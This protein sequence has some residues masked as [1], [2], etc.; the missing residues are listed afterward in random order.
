M[1]SSN[2]MFFCLDTCY[3]LTGFKKMPFYDPSSKGGF[4]MK[5]TA[6]VA[7]LL[8]LGE[9][10]FSQTMKIEMKDKTV[11][12]FLLSE[13]DAITFSA[14]DSAAQPVLAAYYPFNGNANDESGNGHQGIIF[15]ATLTPDRF[16][17][18]NSAYKFTGAGDYIDLGNSTALNP[19]SGLTLTAWMKLEGGSG[20]IRNIVSRWGSANRLPIEERSYSLGV[21]TNDRAY[22]IISRDGTDPGGVVRI[23]DPIKPE[24]NAWYFYAATWDGY[25]MRLYRNGVEVASAPQSAI[26]LSPNLETTI[27]ATRGR[28]GDPVL[29]V[30]NG[31]IDDVRIYNYPLTS[32][33]IIELFHEMNVP[34]PLNLRCQ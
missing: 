24:L 10:S 30:F 23:D 22:F 20:T 31:A 3:K 16:G 33:Q 27:S 15:G 29:A 34:T 26:Y 18:C 32:V 21:N 4:L 12:D 1:L 2:E 6:V 25:M 17:A 8:I 28:V 9:C 19:V 14:Q 11:R 5:T 13:I 7:A